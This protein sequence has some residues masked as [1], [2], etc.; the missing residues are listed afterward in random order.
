MHEPRS[1]AVKQRLCWAE[2]FVA[3]E[4]LEAEV[5]VPALNWS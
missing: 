2:L 5:I 3:G 4:K 1:E